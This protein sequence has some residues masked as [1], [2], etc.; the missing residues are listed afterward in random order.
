M[1]PPPLARLLKEAIGLH[2]RG[3][4]LE[5]ER[6]YREVIAADSSA[7]DAWHMLAL[8][9]A[10]QGFSEPAAKSA[11]SATELRPRIAQYWLTRGKI[12]G[13]RREESEAQ[14]SLRTAAELEPRFAEAWFDLAQSY[15]RE[16]R[17][18][19]AVSAYRS[20]LE[21]NSAPAE[22]HHR[23]A[24]ALLWS[25][26][27]QAALESYQ[28]AFERDP[29][30]HL[31]RDECF[32]FMRTLQFEALPEF[33]HEDMLRFL[34]RPDVD[35]T[36]HASAGL[37]VLMAREAFRKL[38]T[39]SAS[40]AELEVVM[41]D[42][43]FGLLLSDA[44][45]GNSS[46]EAMLTSLRAQF[47]LEEGKRRA[48]PIEF[49]SNLAQQC[50]INE[51]VYAQAPEE[52][53]AAD[54]LAREAEALLGRGV[55]TDEAALRLIAVVAMY[56][57]LHTLRHAQALSALQW[58][59]PA[60]ARLVRRT[61]AEVFEERALRA[62]I[63]GLG[64]IDD[65]VSQRVRN[66]YEENP[67][68]RWL[69]YSRKPPVSCA[70]WLAS[71]APLP[72]GRSA[73]ANPS[74]LVAGCGTGREALFLADGIAG[75]RVTAIDLSLSSLAYA[76]RMASDLRIANVE[77]LQAD[78]LQLDRLPVQFDLVYASG[79]LHHMH[80][81][82]A[83]LAAVVRRA[84]PGGL[85]HVQ[86]YSRRGRAE[87]NQ[88]REIIGNRKLESSAEAIRA[89]R[90]EILRA[91]K[92]SPLRRLLTAR[93]FFS[94]SECRDLLF[95]VQEHQ[96]DLPEI[97]SMVANAGLTV[98]GM[99]KDIPRSAMLAYRRMFPEDPARTDPLRWHAVEEQH[100]ELFRGMY[101]VWC[102][103]QA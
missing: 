85:V 43:L 83:G 47:L 34:R 45:L 70:A 90:Q 98:L 18:G 100:P 30:F 95:H 74:I 79:V 96:F 93:D 91:A 94:M 80:D 97:L 19:E 60:F 5:A 72:Q 44:L 88:A 76:R 9:Q 13:E 33:W 65:P 21:R 77:F 48:A 17:L 24:R 92:D 8:A 16:E 46:F 99:S 66:Q 22:I 82:K 54:A 2:Q 6:I 68:P 64:S 41:R 26:Q 59:E 69:S 63:P 1:L 37:S 86:L 101:R 11:R 27:L 67:Y 20:A 14:V 50:F 32:D 29:Q 52:K 53:L 102:Q 55:P 71:E 84:K 103:R 51:F 31:E 4:L 75:S 61:V 78:I 57:P 7:A 42:P 38:R 49:L 81:P 39:Q 73:P 87:V 62:S 15:E 3:E 56:R 40:S 36:R 58:P 23:L 12:A 10:A 35:R 25:G 89:L 28:R